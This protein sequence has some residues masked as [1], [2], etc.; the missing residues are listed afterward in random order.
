M[1][2]LEGITLDLYLR[3]NK[4]PSAEER[5]KMLRALLSALLDLKRARIVHRD[6]KP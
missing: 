6:I 2:Y 3:R 4:T 1:E 5:R